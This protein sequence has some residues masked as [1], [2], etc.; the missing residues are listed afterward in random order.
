MYSNE[1]LLIFFLYYCNAAH[2]DM[3]CDDNSFCAMFINHTTCSDNNK[4][5]CDSN[6]YE[7]EN[8]KCMPAFSAEC[9]IDEI[10]ATDN[11]MCI[12]NKCQ[13]KPHYIYH[14]SKCVPSTYLCGLL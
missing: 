14:R 9:W 7:I 5:I 6:N 10:C 8:N 12:N 3:P 2:L 13:C 11:A 4:C 1:K